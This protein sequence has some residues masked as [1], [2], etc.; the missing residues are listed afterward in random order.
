MTDLDLLSIPAFLD[1]TKR[2]QTST[3]I[4]HKRRSKTDDRVLYARLPQP[5][6]NKGYERFTLWLN[7]ESPDLGSGVRHVWAKVGRKWAYVWRPGQH[8]VRMRISQFKE[9]TL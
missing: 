3:T 6:S 7:G 2:P 8:R 9:V 1:A 5:P 4:R